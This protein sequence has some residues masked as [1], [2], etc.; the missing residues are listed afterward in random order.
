VLSTTE[1]SALPADASL[2]KQLIYTPRYTGNGTFFVQYKKLRVDYTQLYVGYRFTNSDNGSWLNPFTTGDVR[3][4]LRLDE[5]SR[6]SCSL[7]CS[8]LFNQAYAMVL[9][10]PAAL[11]YYEFTFI[12]QPKI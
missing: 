12:W 5:A 11:R 2:H 7:L 10:R 1:N 6:Y 9:G 4:S 8:N 3:A